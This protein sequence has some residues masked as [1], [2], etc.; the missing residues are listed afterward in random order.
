[1]KPTLTEAIT[2]CMSAKLSSQNRLTSA[3]E[4]RSGRCGMAIAIGAQPMHSSRPLMALQFERGASGST[5]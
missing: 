3:I 1:M 2:A 5:M 4:S